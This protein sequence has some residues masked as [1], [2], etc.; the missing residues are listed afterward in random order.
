MT[1]H[2]SDDLYDRVHAAAAVVRARLGGRAL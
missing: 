1:T 2:A